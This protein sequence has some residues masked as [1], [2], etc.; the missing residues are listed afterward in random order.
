MADQLAKLG[1][2]VVGVGTAKGGTVAT[3][4][5]AS[6]PTRTESARTLAYAAQTTSTSTTATSRTLVLTIGTDWKGVRAVS[7]AS[8]SGSS[9]KSADTVTCV[10]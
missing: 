4:T 1:F 7:V 6:S 8:G 10:S 9:A 5:V 2:V 3:T